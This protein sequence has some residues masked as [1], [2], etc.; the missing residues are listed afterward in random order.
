MMLMGIQMLILGGLAAIFSVRGVLMIAAGL[1]A[2]IYMIWLLGL[3]GYF[4]VS[5]VMHSGNLLEVLATLVFSPILAAVYAPATLFIGW[6]TL[7]AFLSDTLIYAFVPEARADIRHQRH[8][9]REQRQ[10]FKRRTAHPKNNT[11]KADFDL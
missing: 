7:F 4:V 8:Q 10:W 5:L 6:M 1:L 11:S 9:Q 2:V 3:V